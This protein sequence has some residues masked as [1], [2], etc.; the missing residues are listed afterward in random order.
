MSD[1]SQEV[2]QVG[3]SQQTPKVSRYQPRYLIYYIVLTEADQRYVGTMQ[4]TVP[5]DT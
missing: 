5:S 2:F 1:V 4:G 3:N